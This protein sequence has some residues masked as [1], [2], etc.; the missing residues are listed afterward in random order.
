M[1]KMVTYE[2]HDEISWD[3][4]VI[5]VFKGTKKAGEIKP[6]ESAFEKTSFVRARAEGE[7]DKLYVGLG[8]KADITPHRL[9]R[10]GGAA[11]RFAREGKYASVRICREFSDGVLEFC[12]GFMLGAYSFAKYKTGD[13]TGDITISAMKTQA[14]G[15][16]VEKAEA[17]A[18]GTAFARDLAKLSTDE[19]YP[20]SFADMVTER[21]SGTAV[22]VKV[23]KSGELLNEGFVGTEAVGRGGAH[24]PCYVELRYAT[25]PSLPLT[26]LIGKGVTFDMG[27]VNAKQGRDLS[28][29]RGD[30]GGAAAVAGAMDI[31]QAS[32]AK[33][34]IIALIPLAENLPDA[35]A[36]LPGMVLR[37]PQSV[38]VEVKN[39]DAE[40]RLMLA[41]AL[42]HGGW[43]GAA[44]AVDIATLTGSVSAALGNRTAGVFGSDNLCAALISSG[45][46]RGE[47]LWRM[48]LI[49]DYRDYIKSDLADIANI[50]SESEAGSITAALFLKTFVKEGMDW[51]HVDM[52]GV[53]FVK[54]PYGFLTKGAS[55]F[56]ARLLAEF[57]LKG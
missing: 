23:Y 42:L 39:T 57:V 16:G 38:T 41:D 53:S 36:L 31:I 48:P 8:D 1:V 56:G 3:L 14:D 12:E 24:K 46:A 4:I 29:M 34:N 7:T 27:G 17:A 11:G 40:G 15:N 10:A 28:S 13:A 43:L 30:M 44:R 52:A 50:S 20:D 32:G 19:L 6:E 26:A 49:D 18:A 47:L 5:P 35:N 37:Y 9:L 33:A 22:S 2:K 45:E 54:S 55:G 51:A 21:F 25:D